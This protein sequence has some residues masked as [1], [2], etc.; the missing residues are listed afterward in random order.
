MGATNAL[1]AALRTRTARL[2]RKPQHIRHAAPL[3]LSLYDDME[4]GRTIFLSVAYFAS[5]ALVSKQ[6]GRT[7]PRS[8]AGVPFMPGTEEKTRR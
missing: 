6:W 5:W 8:R 4:H 2:R 1:P 7:S 3:G